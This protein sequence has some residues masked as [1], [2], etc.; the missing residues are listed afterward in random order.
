VKLPC[1]G[2]VDA[3]LVLDAIEEGA[4]GIC[5]VGCLE[6]ECHFLKGN[7]MARRQINHAKRILE[8]IHIDPERVEMFNLSASDGPLFAQYAKKFT[9]KLRALGPV[10]QEHV[11]EAT[12]EERQQNVHASE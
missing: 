8:S 9:Q 1:T 6:G 10:F 11:E 12:F 4:D 2:R 5:V 7:I 3:K